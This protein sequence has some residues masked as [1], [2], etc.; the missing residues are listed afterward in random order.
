MFLALRTVAHHREGCLQWLG[1]SRTSY[2]F[3]TTKQIS[4][5]AQTHLPFVTNSLFVC[6]SRYMNMLNQIGEIS[7]FHHLANIYFPWIPQQLG[8]C[9]SAATLTRVTVLLADIF[10]PFQVDMV[11]FISFLLVNFAKFML[12]KEQGHIQATGSNLDNIWFDKGTEESSCWI[13]TIPF[14]PIH[15][16][17]AHEPVQ[18][19]IGDVSQCIVFLD[20]DRT[21]ILTL[22]IYQAATLPWWPNYKNLHPGFEKW[23]KASTYLDI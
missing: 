2:I 11:K 6:C 10:H 15:H 8:S 14:M 13:F 20:C 21:Q 12:R 3:K 1:Y 5:V 16:F 7:S 18:T 9:Q 4:H 17:T 19:S 22:Q 23:R